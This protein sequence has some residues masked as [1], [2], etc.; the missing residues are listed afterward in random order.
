MA[1]PFAGR[2][3]SANL[4]GSGAL[5]PEI[6]FKRRRTFTAQKRS[7]RPARFETLEPRIL[8][9]ADSLVP[10]LTATLTDGL[11][12][13]S[14]RFGE[15]LAD[16]PL[17]TEELL[18]TYVPGVTQAGEESLELVELRDLLSKDLNSLELSPAEVNALDDLDVI[19]PDDDIV[20]WE[21]A[22]QA[23]V[24]DQLGDWLT[25]GFVD[26]GGGILELASDLDSYLTGLTVQPQY[27]PYI[28]L[29][30]NDVDVT[31]VDESRFSV[32]MDFEFGFQYSLFA[33]LGTEANLLSIS[34]NEADP[35][36]PDTEIGI[37]GGIRF[38]DFN[39][40]ARLNSD[41]EATGYIMQIPGDIEIFAFSDEAWNIDLNIG[42]LGVEAT[43]MFTV[44]PTVDATI[45][46]P[47]HPDAIG[48]ADNQLE[49]EFNETFT[50][51]EPLPTD[52][53]LHTDIIL[54]ITIAGSTSRVTLDEGDYSDADGIVT[55]INA[56]LLVAGLDDIL[57]ASNVGG[58]LQLSVN[59]V[60][61][62]PLG[63]PDNVGPTTLITAGV[64]PGILGD[65]TAQDIV[66]LLSVAGALPKRVSFTTT[67]EDDDNNND[68]TLGDL[69]LDGLKAD[70]QA[71]LDSE[72][73][74][75]AIT[76][77]DNAG[78]ITLSS[79]NNL[80]IT[81]NFEFGTDNLITLAELSVTPISELIET[82]ATDTGLEM[83]L[84]LVVD[85]AN[86]NLDWA[87]APTVDLMADVNAFT[88]TDVV[89]I[90][91]D[92]PTLDF[93]LTYDG[94]TKLIDSASA[95]WQELLDF[96]VIASNEIIA[97]LGQ[98]G[99]YLDRL[100][101]SSPLGAFDLAFIEGTLG[102]V[103]DFADLIQDTLLF[104]DGDDGPGEDIPDV[105]K[106][107]T[108]ID[109]Q[110]QLTFNN[111]Q[112]L[113]DRLATILGLS[114]SDIGTTYDPVTNELTYQI[115]LQHQ[116]FDA[117]Q[118]ANDGDGIEFDIDFDADE[119]LGGLGPLVDIFADAT[120]KLDVEGN[121]NAI[122]GF[123]MGDA[124]DAI[125]DDISA[126]TGTVLDDLN[127]GR[128]VVIN[129]HP[130]LSGSDPVTPLIGRLSESAIFFVTIN[131]GS[132][133][134]VTVPKSETD[135]NQTLQN[136]IDDVNDALTLAGLD[137]NII[138]EKLDPVDDSLS[139]RIV[140]RAQ[141][142]SS[143]D[144]FQVDTSSGNTAFTE[145]GLQ[146]ET[147]ATVSVLGDPVQSINDP[148]SL[149]IE[150]LKNGANTMG[151]ISLNST[152]VGPNNTI[153][154]LVLDINDAIVGTNL[155]DQIFATREGNSIRFNAV[156]ADIESF[157]VS[158]S[159]D[160]GFAV[161]KLA[162]ISLKGAKPAN[163]FGLLNN[164]LN[165]DIDL[166]LS[167]GATPSGT[168][169]IAPSAT[170]GDDGNSANS[171]VDDLVA[172]INAEITSEGLASHIQA[173]SD[174]FRIGFKAI[175]TQ[176]T[177][178]TLSNLDDVSSDTEQ[179]GLVND[180][181]TPSLRVIANK[182][183]PLSYGVINDASF[184]LSV[185]G[186]T[187]NHNYNVELSR[188][189]TL[190]NRSIYD[191]AGDIRAA[192]SSA[193]TEYNE[194]NSLDTPNPFVVSVQTG[195]IV[196]GLKTDNG[197][198][199]LFGD[200]ITDVSA[201]ITAFSVSGA[202]SELNLSG[203]AN[204]D[205][206][207]IETLDGSSF[208]VS[209]DDLTENTV[210]EVLQR[211][212][213][214]ATAATV[215]VV[216]EIADDGASL[217]L[218]DNTA[219]SGEFQVR[220]VN[221][222]PA[223]IGLGLFA[224]GLTQLEQFDETNGEAVS[225]NVIE[226][227]TIAQV[228]LVDRFTIAEVDNDTPL[229]SAD[230]EVS[231]PDGVEASATFGFAGIRLYSQQNP[232]ATSGGDA[233]NDVEPIDDLFN[234]QLALGLADGRQSLGDLLGSLG[235]INDL[236][237]RIEA[238]TLT[239][240]GDDSFTL[241]VEVVPELDII[242]LGS[243]ASIDFSIAS[244][245]SMGFDSDGLFRLV[246]APEVSI[247]GNNLDDLANFEDVRFDDIL[248]ALSAIAEFL[249]QFAELDFL[250]EELPVL[251]LSFN[252]ILDIAERFSQAVEDIQA[253]PAGGIQALEQ[254]IRETFNL[255][256]FG[257]D[258]DA[259]NAFFDNLGIPVSEAGDLFDML[260][261]GA[262][263]N[264]LRI[265]LRLPVGFSEGR[266]IDLDLGD[267]AN[268]GGVVDLQGAAG[269]NVSGYLDARLSLGV[270]LDTLDV[271]LYN[272]VS[273][274]NGNLSAG[275]E[276]V[277][278]NAAIGPLGA[279]VRDGV[280][281]A[282]IE[283][284]FEDA[285][286]ADTD[287][288][289]L[290]DIGTLFDSFDA[291]LVGEIDTT[292]PVYVPT[293]SDYLGDI[294]LQLQDS[295]GTSITLSGDGLDIP[296]FST[297]GV[298]SLPD[299][300]GI[301]IGSIDLFNS[302]PLM[303]DGLDFFLEGVQSLL[304][305]EVFGFELPFI[306][307]QLAG[308]ADFIEDLREDILG[309]VREL[310]ELAPELGEDIVQHLLF[311][312]LGPGTGALPNLPGLGQ[313][314]EDFLGL[315]SSI[316][317]LNI[318]NNY[319]TGAALPGVI[320]EAVIDAFL[321][322]FNNSIEWR[323]R[324][325][326]TYTPPVDIDF[327]L[328]FPGLNL[329]VDAPL[330]VEF[331][332]DLALGVGVNTTDGAYL[333]IDNER[334]VNNNTVNEELYLA[335]SATLDDSA[336]I[337]GELGFLQLE[338]TPETADFDSI[339]EDDADAS[340]DFAADDDP[341]P[342]AFQAS[343]VVDLQ[344]KSDA[345]DDKLSFSELGSLDAAINID[346]EAEVNL[347]AVAK[348][349]ES[350]L[351]DAIAAI[352]PSVQ[353]NFVFD[354]AVTSDGGTGGD[355]GNFLG[356]F[357]IA[358]SLHILAFDEVGLDLGSFLGDFL[359]PVIGKIQEVT[360]PLQPII[361]VVTTPIP[362]ISD[363]FGPTTLVDIAEMTGYV[364]AGLIYAIA[365]IITLVNSIPDNPGSFILPL[366]SFAII[367]P[368]SGDTGGLASVLTNPNARLG[369]DGGTGAFDFNAALPDGFS[370][371]LD[372]VTDL[373]DG[374][375][376]TGG[377]DAATGEQVKDLINDSGEG[378]DSG[379]AFP[380]F[381]TP[382]E[383]FNLLLGEN[384]ALVT[385]DLAP[386]GLD[387][388]Y[389]QK[390]PIWGPIFGRLGMAA[391]LNI[392]LAFGYDTEGARRFADG[393]FTNPLDLLAG[394]FISD[395]D[396]PSGTGGTD[397]PELSFYGELIAGAEVG[398][399]FASVGV[400][401]GIK[402]TVNFDLYDPDSDGRVR[403]DESLAAF[404]YEFR[405]GSPVLAPIAIFDVFGDIT[406]QLRAFIEFLTFTKK[407]EITPPIT[408]F[409]FSIDFDR[410]PILATERGDGSLLLNI[411]PNS[412]GRYNGN[413]AD[414]D[415]TIYVESAGDNKV[416]VWSGPLGVPENAKQVYE[417]GENKLIE[418]YG[419]EGNDTINLVGV[420]DPDIRFYIE[421]GSGD[422][423]IV[424]GAGP[425]VILGGDGADTLTG[426]NSDDI[427]YGNAGPDTISGL[428]GEDTIFGDEGR[429]SYDDTNPGEEENLVRSRILVFPNDTDG[430]DTIDGGGDNDLIF[431]GGESDLIQGGTGNDL[432]IGDIGRLEF[433]TTGGENPVSTG[434]IA[435]TSGKVDVSKI[436][437]R[438]EGA[439]DRLFGNEDNDTIL[440]GFGDDLIDGAEG[441]D[442][443]LGEVGFDTIYGGSDSDDILGGTE[444]DIIFG[445]RDPEYTP[446]LGAPTEDTDP[447]QDVAD[448]IDGEFGND[449]IRGNQG[450]DIIAGNRG[451][452]I[453]FGDEDDD[454]ITGGEGPDTIFG[455]A[456]DDTID[457]GES[458]DVVFG[459]DG[460]VVHYDFYTNPGRPVAEGTAVSAAITG[461]L[462]RIDQVTG[463][464][465]IGDGAT[466]L[467]AT[468]AD[469]D[470]DN[471]GPDSNDRS[472][473]LIITEVN[474]STDG[475]DTINGGN[476]LDIV[477]GGAGDDNVYG[478]FDPLVPFS[479]PRPTGNDVLIGDGGR[480]EFQDRRYS[481]IATVQNGN[482]DGQDILTGNDGN[483]YIL[484][485]GNDDDLYGFE[486]LNAPN[487][488]N[489]DDLSAAGNDL[490][491]IEDGV[492][493]DDDDIIAGDNAEI[494]FD[495]GVVE[496]IA[497][498][499]T[500]DGPTGTGGDDE[501][502]GFKGTD[503]I[504]GGVNITDST[505]FLF[506]NQGQDVLLGDNGE[507]DYDT[508][509]NDL[510]TLDLIRSYTDGLGG[511]DEISGNA[512]SDVIIGG[513]GGDD[514]FGDDAGAYHDG[515][516][517][518]DIILGDNA[519]VIMDGTDGRLLVFGSAVT[520]IETTDVAESTGGADLIEGNA[521]AD[522]ILG[523][524]ND[525]GVDTIYG[526][527][528][529]P[530]VPL[531]G[532]DSALGDNGLLDFA[533][534]GDT[535]LNTLDLIRSKPDNLGGRDI[536]SGNAGSDALIGGT[537]GDD[538]HGDDDV[539]SAEGSD[540][541][542]ITLGDNAD[543]FLAG[544]LGEL[545]VQGT[546]VGE[547]ITTD[548]L[549]TTGGADFIEGNTGRDVIAGGVD[550]DELHGDARVQGVMDG[551]D[552]LLGDQSLLRWNIA[553]S[554]NL[555]EVVPGVLA[556]GDDDPGTLD[557]IQ[558]F[559]TESLGDDDD[560]YGNDGNDVAMGGTGSDE[561]FG[562]FY[563]D[564]VLA[565]A[566]DPG[567][568]TLIGDG[569][570]ITLIDYNRTVIRSIE[571]GLGDSDFIRG[572]DLN[573]II[574]G[575]FAGD[576]LYGE[577]MIANLSLIETGAG[578]DWILGDNAR[579]DYTL[580]SDTLL[581]R[582]DVL[583]YLGDTEV[584]L[585][586]DSANLDRVTTTDPT[587]G[588]NDVIYGN[589]NSS[590]DANDFIFGGTGS[591]TIRGDSDDVSPAPGAD[592]PD[593]KDIILGDHGKL[594][595]TLPAVDNFFVENNFFSI[596]T[597]L[598]DLGAGDILF[599][600]ANDDV[601][602]GGQGDDIMFG[603][604]GDD[605]L[606][607]G[608]NVAD[609]DDDLDGMPDADQ[610]AISPALLADLNPSDVNDINDMMDGGGDDD[611]MAG[612]NA[613]IVRQPNF[614]GSP[615]DGDAL[616]SLRF[617][618][619]GG[620]GERYSIES[621][622]VDGIAEVDVGFSANVTDDFQPHQDM[623]LVRTVVLLDH[624]DLIEN[625]AVANAADPRPF[626]N[627][628]M[629]GGSED[630]EM[631]GQLGDDIVQG[632]GSIS[633]V[634]PQVNEASLDPYNPSQSAD[635]S[636]DLRNFDIRV[637]LNAANDTAAT[638]RFEVGE[639][640]SDGDDY[641]E[642]NGGND[643]L[644]GNLGQDDLIGG[645]SI[646]FGLD[647]DNPVND[648]DGSLP[649]HLLRPDGG[650][651]IYG[652]AGNPDLLARN[653]RV[654]TGNNTIV[655]D[656]E[657]HARDADTILG[658]NGSIFRLVA[659][660][661]D[662]DGV[663]IGYAAYNYDYDA[664]TLDGFVDDGFGD[665]SLQLIPRAVEFSD[666]G[667]SYEDH[668]GDAGTREVLTFSATA[669]GEG[670]LIFG[671]SGDDTIHGMFGADTIFGNSE[672]DD[673]HGEIGTDWIV[674][675]TGIDGLVG[676][677]GLILT[678]RNDL[679]AEPLNG[680]AA[681]NP[682]QTNLKKNDEVDTNALNAIIST[683]GNIQYEIINI[684]GELIKAAELFAFRTD[685]IDDGVVSPVNEF[686]E[687]LRWND[688]LFG[689][690][691]N[692][693]IHAGD[694]DDGV[695]GAEALPAYYSGA[696]FSLGLNQEFT[697]INSFL[698]NMQISPPNGTPDLADN[699]FWFEFAPYNPGDVLR[700]EGKEIVSENGQGLRTLDEFAWYDEFNPRRKIMF[701]Y[702]AG[703]GGVELLST[704]TGVAN[705]IDFLLNFDETEGPDG[706]EFDGDDAPLP[707]D[708]ADR[709]FG[710]LGNDIIFGGTGRDHMYGGR[711]NDLLNMDDNHD[712]GASNKVGPKAPTPDPLDNTLSDEF[713]AYADIVYSGAGRD[714][715]ILNTGADRATD[716]V[717]EFNSYLVPFSPFGA[718][719]ISRTLQPQLPEFLFDMSEADG[720]DA[721]IISGLILPSALDGQLYVDQKNADV[722]TDDPDPLRNFEPFGELGMVRQT[723][724]DWQEQ[725]GAPN[726][727]QPG[728]FK[729]KREIMRR[730]LFTDAELN[731][732][733]PDVGN[734]VVSG[735]N[736]TAAPELLGEETVA[737]TI[738]DEIQ[739]SYIEILVTAS[740]EKDKAGSKSNA[741]AIFDYQGP[742]D[743]KFAGIEVGTDKVQIGHRDASGWVIDAQVPMQLAANAEYELTI[744]VWDS[745]ATLYVTD[746]S[747]NGNG[748]GNGPSGVETTSV[749]FNFGDALNDNGMLGLGSDN[750]TASFDDY[751][752]Q[753][754]PPVWT[755]TDAEDFAAGDH[756]FNEI[757]GSWQLGG[758]SLTGFASTDSPALA[759]RYMPIDSFARLELE[760]DY[761]TDG[762]A[763]LV[764]DYISE[765]NYKFVTLN[766][767]SNELYLGHM[768]KQGLQI[769]AVTGFDVDPAGHQLT[770]TMLGTTASVAIDGQATLT[771]VFN[772]LL[773]DGSFGMMVNE[774][775][776]NYED[777]EVRTD[778]P[779]YPQAAPLQ[780]PASSSTA[781]LM[782]ME[783]PFTVPSLSQAI[784]EADQTTTGT[785]LSSD[786][787]QW[788]VYG[789]EDNLVGDDS[790]WL[791]VEA[792]ADGEDHKGQV[793]W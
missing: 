649:N 396:L 102:E 124:V 662:G 258:T 166:T 668:D 718:F 206:L 90:D 766:D 707:T 168:I 616:A 310:I 600:N 498:T 507:L 339:L 161:S 3:E 434:N 85:T 490:L 679:L 348:F 562:D 244:L 198:T 739:P 384:A 132:A 439:R 777:L 751:Q 35:D 731:P 402:I 88:D 321:P 265:D 269:L 145:L 182:A 252:E 420:T 15:L 702:D 288:L 208:S 519:D 192:I 271:V 57:T 272:G 267:I 657:R 719:H 130:A 644:Y 593:G 100:Q 281:N 22:F 334:E 21:E 54:D 52:G 643:R 641:I 37:K 410:E 575:G 436:S 75:G 483:D 343:F 51:A 134:Q 377:N 737:L 724:R 398:I 86:D 785:A 451:S 273:G 70:L 211:I 393:G 286:A 283:F 639:A 12:D 696:G 30:V 357:N 38:T 366:G 790:G 578:D 481:Y 259:L 48:I 311:A 529:T 427:I 178:I 761:Q 496:R 715:M 464:R 332:W 742:E 781:P 695:S 455:G 417:L 721:S 280:I 536:V 296:D 171:D 204:S 598:A 538:I 101:A 646:L 720:A 636:F 523:G 114:K 153:T 320:D 726:D 188:E 416:K 404:L 473:D 584:T 714:V 485:G 196:I 681:R 26:D 728:N 156:N 711:G 532:N 390:F 213:D 200:L 462:I 295:Q 687:A 242:G 729:G 680:I 40:G 316:P 419:G 150:F 405:T 210:G 428:A 9:S 349:N 379:F 53:I 336:S 255:P 84:E 764:F 566:D 179:T 60:D 572:N 486:V 591:D 745:V 762:E 442:Q 189:D 27:A 74:G 430:A 89:F 199:N 732:F 423:T 558:T 508:G 471:S 309:P 595:P 500:N 246:D 29:I 194:D 361:D 380:I 767:S 7:R 691:E 136:L 704:L 65:T 77:G 315:S 285:A 282:D 399:G 195:S 645:S 1:Y 325:G 279:F 510:S 105:N 780:A 615:A 774:G 521:D 606:I 629:A 78:R 229:L 222:S 772:S 779:N 535:D 163:P 235:D 299:F 342:T 763:G 370:E 149:D 67:P 685:D 450:N 253:N 110:F 58:T 480:V 172:D 492:F 373:I 276:N 95:D 652:G 374:A 435:M 470:A 557:L 586:S 401:G 122:L 364:E 350:I 608:H 174:G 546:A 147:A 457:S 363:L 142:S 748:N 407:I 23:V 589:G 190:T 445:F 689:G 300:S 516:D 98:L 237:S 109:D 703:P 605:D 474:N 533:F 261:E 2:D 18:D 736:M 624:S 56:E 488:D 769:D 116:F 738:L 614:V 138:A 426:G 62:S 717:G 493:L 708:G 725:T 264:T 20:T 722:R 548:I 352:L 148:L 674:G 270:N 140:L 113:T 413:T 650:D 709:A 793:N 128:G 758:D 693:F 96:T 16:D 623:E 541:N 511:Q 547:I 495:E 579:L 34:L 76:V 509:D 249:S 181:V 378:S 160:A 251:G 447:N 554:E 409:E 582:Q 43:G 144:S 207:V 340:N 106:L 260:L 567:E 284:S 151:S 240:N 784:D 712:S 268:L 226:G 619:T 13:L 170:N 313:T 776:A 177:G 688:I 164:T 6:P 459:D 97:L 561:I 476:G 221:G 256:D 14:D 565:A 333:V 381:E 186:A 329:D 155:E 580:P 79:L 347:N 375:F 599:G 25:N 112:S 319:E 632:D 318:L 755:L 463:D 403:V 635:Q 749:S 412:E 520:F 537:G 552:V 93:D 759:I 205:D 701:D 692:D 612:D 415:E 291:V 324:L 287:T 215:N 640:V 515:D 574:I 218:T 597:Q 103:L 262:G 446:T 744:T 139:N 683:P 387:F 83:D 353:T 613:I 247:T 743:F 389:T 550:S 573:D 765:E 654:D 441:E 111:V 362:V 478:D 583:N 360:D 440:G 456:D 245:G 338:I 115:S 628:I 540:G 397:V 123:Q 231:L 542:D 630:D 444:D 386:F 468:F 243:G 577:A 677:D 587:L 117:D 611:V 512:G 527:A 32:T 232:P 385:Y 239:T 530:K 344:N 131:D 514:L 553:V 429:I 41:N 143:M 137:S 376:G 663:D 33:D 317:G 308:G 50:A 460:L 768:G 467:L 723:D 484:G 560:I 601:M 594:Y 682:E 576:E 290:T 183:A 391:G 750:A 326:D 365:D 133:V 230:L 603:G 503:V 220:L 185:T 341:D 555:I 694:G 392:D 337:S 501:A 773:N 162:A 275:A 303:L 544:T 330:D 746:P 169:N 263:N 665:D 359:G 506:G 754:L 73:G 368:D 238:P 236:V 19:D 522:I 786:G 617:R 306:G 346:A 740:S 327:D 502:Y 81:Q 184:Q 266:A 175:S 61:P 248:G 45:V 752:V 667:Y 219:G 741:Y 209:L 449:Y 684:E 671:E 356:D 406:A 358:D 69:S 126:A 424:S 293:D 167:N 618:M 443:L 8:L 760:I 217:K 570:E 698:Q 727:P 454:E 64:A 734:F 355:D 68:T 518:G 604:L 461:S 770:L 202:P 673:L 638:L 382:S 307:D 494:E 658:D 789:D 545:V 627:D 46:D 129:E 678:S 659:D 666:Y 92:V 187:G 158:G 201:E 10:G 11:D 108:Y 80:E 596:D 472:L 421:G 312:I 305:G 289:S 173:F 214:A 371:G 525:G 328:G 783:T 351:P 418:A 531:D 735:G 775:N 354:W 395:T 44:D 543:I 602:I 228:P 31:F 408:L 49:I 453:I 278:F 36:T 425:A 559:A 448:V 563:F 87:T 63:L 528:A 91:G 157:T 487:T 99:T 437:T 411:G 524:V 607:G 250:S 191:L 778:D 655:S 526:D 782:N 700:F 24:V 458:G 297:P 159:A 176:V 422:D 225:P 438:G 125:N 499:D 756:G 551:D 676:D 504:L 119:F 675:G 234:A 534:D 298:L 302:I 323:F 517:L 479:G 5:T 634:T 648:P 82:V 753:K 197:G 414:I 233:D 716:W 432:I 653:A 690:L 564:G 642:G 180:S 165:F 224:S 669:R 152:T 792:T 699:P 367:G 730:E 304:D 383:I 647:D 146:P 660:L 55:E 59:G 621:D 94:V 710:D 706:P 661:D 556:T 672:H 42:F 581:N 223:A 72:F 135:T 369:G 47:S 475:N 274:I 569:G 713:Q 292:L 549:E 489:W 322:F 400:E 571:Q 656:D 193:I 664:T 733:A 104:D 39:F 216:A 791:E 335:V 372:A 277:T 651:M 590:G 257:S 497:T 771:H 592:G 107:L 121:L 491:E 203:S 71:A 314:L 254:K 466:A 120:I 477:L 394:F 585:D 28:N 788:L 670:D 17:D 747:S 388:S 686:G 588:G 431:G 465:L 625:D 66:F 127:G 620:S 637:D 452:D 757:A 610:L 631:W 787:R 212:N 705:P 294:S 633:I 154:D 227:A 609:G 568:D 482:Q 622:S 345:N 118:V 697:G 469:D 331:V 141:D 513:T 505:D 4:T 539:A 433:A 301:D 626:G 241:Q